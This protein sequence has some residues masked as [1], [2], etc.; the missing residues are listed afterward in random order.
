MVASH[1]TYDAEF[2][3]PLFEIERR[4]FWFQTRNRVITTLVEQVVRPLP[5]GYRVLE[6]GCGTGNVLQPLAETC[7]AGTVVGMDLFAE[8]LHFARRRVPGAVVQGDLHHPP[9]RTAFEVIGLFDVLEHF[10][11]DRRVLS[12][13]ATMLAPGG[14]LILTVPAYRSLWSYFDVASHHARR[15]ELADLGGKLEDAGLR[16]EYLSPYMVAA[17]PVLWGQRRLRF[18]KQEANAARAATVHDLRIVP[19]ANEVF[20]WLCAWEPSAV[21]QHRTLPFG[22]SLIALARRR[23]E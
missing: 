20:R 13:L 8:G 2:F 22:T 5:N 14:A 7:H 4:H 3:G 23:A 19:I 11:D 10:E 1:Q 12:D 21:A 17:F 9:F 18:G 16:V 15:Y 6:V